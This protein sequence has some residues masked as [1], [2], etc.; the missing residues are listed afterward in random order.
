MAQPPTIHKIQ[1]QVSDV[2][3]GVYETLDLRVA[4]HPS[5]TVRYMI[6]RVLAYALS[7]EDGIAFSRGGISSPEEPPLAVHDATGLLRAWIE[8]GMPSAERL[9]KASKAAPRLALY[10]VGDLALL[11]KDAK[12]R[13]IHKVEAIDIWPLPLAI[14]ERL[15]AH[16]ARELRFEL[17]RSDGVLY[18][19]VAGESL[20]APL[21]RV[22][23]AEA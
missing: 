18:V 5:E 6:V 3:R 21:E 16:T 11:R 8:V 15:E 1:V 19:T 22:S 10:T 2:D 4:R 7:Y 20:E 12:S 17:T 23:L 13:P 9:H 14:V